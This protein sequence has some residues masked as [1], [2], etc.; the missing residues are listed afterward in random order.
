MTID[1]KIG[2]LT[3]YNAELFIESEAGVTGP[4][5]DMGLTQEE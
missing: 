5:A 3:Q 2:Q 1:E 4:M